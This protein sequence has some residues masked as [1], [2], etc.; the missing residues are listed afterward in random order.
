MGNF[1]VPQQ[2]RQ[3]AAHSLDRPS[4][5]TSLPKHAVHCLIGELNFLSSSV[6]SAGRSTGRDRDLQVRVP[7]GCHGRGSSGVA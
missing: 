5:R 2:I 6:H 1:R 4:G 7:W 3:R